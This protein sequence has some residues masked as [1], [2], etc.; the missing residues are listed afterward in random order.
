M[1]IPMRC[2]NCGQILSSKYNTY[3]NLVNSPIL[4]KKEDERGIC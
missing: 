1:I 4:I 3:I 2:F